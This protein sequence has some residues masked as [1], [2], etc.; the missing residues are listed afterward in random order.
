MKFSSVFLRILTA[1]MLICFCSESGD[2]TD[3]L[4][5]WRPN[6]K[7]TVHRMGIA[8]DEAAHVKKYFVVDV[9][10]H[11]EDAYLYLS[12]PVKKI[13]AE[14]GVKFSG[15]ILIAEPSQGAEASLGLS[16]SL[17]PCL[18]LYEFGKDLLPWVRDTEG[19][20]LTVGGDLDALVK[21]QVEK[22][23]PVL[24]M[25]GVK[26][27]NVGVYINRIV[28]YMRPLAGTGESRLVVYVD[29]PQIIGRPVDEASYERDVV[30]VRWAPVKAAV[31][32]CLAE[33]NK[34]LADMSAEVASARNLSASGE[35]IRT[36]LR[37]RLFYIKY[38]HISEIEWAGFLIPEKK[39]QI[40]SL[41]KNV[42]P[43][44]DKMKSLNN[45]NR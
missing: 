30:A 36:K 14:G 27:E 13:P 16:I 41:L 20:W 22:V 44:I 11:E 8:C 7:F 5:F 33:W 12:I 21:P 28:L 17:T 10:F 19:K 25:G 3:N 23:L 42:A 43:E 39:A 45:E 35:A 24:N 2:T 29:N 38:R 1:G 40:E 18:P 15:R 9:T 6:G 31:D 26:F 34:K 37:D 4:L 32:A